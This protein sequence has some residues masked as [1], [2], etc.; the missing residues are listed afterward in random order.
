MHVQSGVPLGYRFHR[1]LHAL[2]YRLHSIID[3]LGYRV[4]RLPYP[5]ARYSTEFA[6]PWATGSTDFSTPGLQIPQHVLPLGYIVNR[7]RYP[8][9]T[10]STDTQHHTTHPPAHTRCPVN[11]M[12]CL[13]VGVTTML[14]SMASKLALDLCSNQLLLRISRHQ[15]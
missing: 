11:P 6:T 2:D 10:E 4:H 7:I 8:W 5:W 13:M 15:S 14:L 12:G 3:P 1:L 9:A